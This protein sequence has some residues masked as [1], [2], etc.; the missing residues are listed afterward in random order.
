[1]R[2]M[3]YLTRS[4]IE[5]KPTIRPDSITGRWRMRRCVIS[6]SAVS[7]DML[8]ETVCGGEV[9][10]FVN[11]ASRT[12]SPCIAIWRTTS[13]QEQ[14]IGNASCRERGCQYVKY[15]GSPDK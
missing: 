2:S 7:T 1:M 10:T 12:A 15:R 13:S 3:R 14:K 9:I 6:E 5:T 4:P 11:G 8:G